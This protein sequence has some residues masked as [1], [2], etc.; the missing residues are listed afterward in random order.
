[1]IPTI[2]DSTL[3]ATYTREL[4]YRPDWPKNYSEAISDPVIAA[5]LRTLARHVPT[6]GRR[7]ADRARIGIGQA[8]APA[9][10]QACA[11][12]IGTCAGSVVN[13]INRQG[14]RCRVTVDSAPGA[15]V[16]LPE[17]SGWRLHSPAPP[18]GQI[19]L[20]RRASGEKPDED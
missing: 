17:P 8:P 18:P 9:D 2:S 4:P 12:P 10:P 16:R 14:Q 19:D 11:C 6:Y 13:G 15:P 7:S 20:K 3:R 1:M 5:I